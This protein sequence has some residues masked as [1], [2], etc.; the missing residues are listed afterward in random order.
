MRGWFRWDCPPRIVAFGEWV[1]RDLGNVPFGLER[2]EILRVAFVVEIVLIDRFSHFEQGSLQRRL[3]RARERIR[4]SN[5]RRSRESGYQVGHK[6]DRRQ[7]PTDRR[8]K[9][10]SRWRLN[11]IGRLI[12]R[13]IAALLGLGPC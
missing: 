3:F 10:M 7:Q 4:L 6:T 1:R 9:L 2:F 12:K 11:M 13:R 8:V 5:D